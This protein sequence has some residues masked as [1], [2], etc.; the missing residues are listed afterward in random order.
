MFAW[1]LGTS[2]KLPHI[3]CL[4]VY[5]KKQPPE[6]NSGDR[7]ILETAHNTSWKILAFIYAKSVN[8]ITGFMLLKLFF[9]EFIDFKTI[10]QISFL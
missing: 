7:Y 8:N 6:N 5:Q 4:L 9:N 3:K 1:V 10:F 2:L